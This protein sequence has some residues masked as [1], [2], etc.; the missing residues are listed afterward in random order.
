MNISTDISE[1]SGIRAIPKSYWLYVQSAL[2]KEDCG[3]A[4]VHMAN[5]EPQLI[6]VED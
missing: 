5:Q 2:D 6:V 1:T 4:V 3:W